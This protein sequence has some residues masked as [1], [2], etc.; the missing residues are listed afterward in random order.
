MMGHGHLRLDPALPNYLLGQMTVAE[1]EQVRSRWAEGMRALADLLYEQ[2]FQD[3]RL[4]AQ[5]TLLELPNLLA[6]LDWAQGALTP[7]E[8]VGLSVRLEA[9]LANLGRL[10]AL[11][12]ATLAREQAAR[13]LGAWSYAQFESL[14]Q[15]I[16]RMM[17]QGR[18]PEA[19]A[20][21]E[22]LLARTLA[23]GEAA[24][25]RAAYDIAFA[26]KIFG[27]VMKEI[28]AAETALTSLNE[29]QRRFQALADAGNIS[30]ERMA[31]TTITEAANCLR[32]LG[33]YDE[34]AAAFEES[35]RR[36]EKLGNRRGAA[37]GRGQLG[38]VHRRQ[39]R[40]DEA[41]ESFR[42]ALRIFESLSESGGVA[43]SWYQIGRV[44]SEAGQFEQAEQAYRQSLAIMVQQQD[45]SGEARILDGL[46][47][48]YNQMGRL[49]E[50]TTFYRQA[51][52][53]FTQLQDQRNEG[54]ARNNL[55]KDLIKMQR[56][57]EARH[58]L[59][60][61]IE[62]IKPFGHAAEPWTSWGNLHVLEQE[63]GDAQAAAAAREQAIASYLAYR[64]AG[65]ESQSNQAELLALVFQAIQQGAT[66][67]AEQTLA[68]LSKG[69]TPVWLN[70]LLAKLQ[71]ILRGDRNPA[72]ADDPN[73]NYD[74][75]AELQL[76]LEVLG[77]K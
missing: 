20:A 33:R 62:C 8:V 49:E 4:A 15:G 26:H 73:L 58:E 34:A 74:N 76:L 18:L 65:G 60:R 32:D 22:Q 35:I 45:R 54:H 67:E 36:D 72:L 19:K 64:R 10:R 59:R 51:V 2:A 16:E 12:Q 23:A 5:L 56:Y 7:E 25:A 3:S 17:E 39:K 77:A 37:V 61:A 1:Q 55:A 11:A 43:I 46:G 27:S 52:N 50:A 68:E 53:I 66:T 9:R 75:A 48:L 31:S 24:Y 14:E 47:H 71:A 63:T 21:A 28:G 6:L 40:Y 42:G 13:A 38:T 70:T 30:A 41:M 44:H 69:D 57:D 29:A